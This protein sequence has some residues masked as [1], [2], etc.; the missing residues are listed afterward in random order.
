MIEAYLLHV[1]PWQENGSLAFAPSK[2]NTA[3][4]RMPPGILKK[5]ND[6]V[7]NKIH[8]YLVA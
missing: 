7:Q 4:M 2:Y 3:S 5:E 8:V 6:K 1:S